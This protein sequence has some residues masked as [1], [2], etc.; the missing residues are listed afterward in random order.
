MIHPCCRPPR[1][2]PEAGGYTDHLDLPHDRPVAA[3]VRRGVAGVLRGWGFRDPMW[4][5][6]A[7]LVAN[8]LVVNAVRHGGGCLAVDLHA[9]DGDVTVSVADGSPV[10]PSPRVCDLTGG[11]GLIIVEALTVAWGVHEHDGGKQVWAQLAPCPQTRPTTSTTIA[12]T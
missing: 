3:T 10:V 5:H 7:V 8:E 1:G 12:L 9:H 11:R 4:L 6:D 2:I